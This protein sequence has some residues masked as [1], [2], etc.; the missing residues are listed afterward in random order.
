MSLQHLGIVKK[1]KQIPNASIYSLTSSNVIKEMF[2]L[3]KS[4]VNYNDRVRSP[5]GSITAQLAEDKHYNKELFSSVGSVTLG[6]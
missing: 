5:S 2:I 1:I 3:K 6:N 4:N